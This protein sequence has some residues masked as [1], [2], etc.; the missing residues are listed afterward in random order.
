MRPHIY[1]LNFLLAALL[2]GVASAQRPHNIWDPPF[3]QG[4]AAEVEDTIITFEEIRREMAPL[5]PGIRE[6]S[7]SR[8]E[9]NRQ[10]EELYLE[11]LGSLVDRAI[12]LREF[13]NREFNIPQSFI[14]SR[15][16]Q[17]LAEDFEGD[18]ARFHE[19][20]RNQGKSVREFRRQV[21]EDIIIGAMRS[22]RRRS[23]SQISPER[24]ER[25]YNEN[26]LHF[27][28]E[29]SVRLRVIMLRPLADESPDLMRQQ[30]ERVMDELARGTPFAEVASRFSQDPR[31][32]RGGDW[33]WVLRRNLRDEMAEAAFDLNVGE[34]SDPIT[35]GN[36][37]FIIFVE[38]IREEGIQP[39]N[40]VRER[41]EQILAQ[42][43][44]RQD[45]QQWIE[46]L[47]RNAFIRYY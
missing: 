5:I 25:F 47:R 28:E 17:I 31:R 2:A 19:F 26:K 12:I 10:M 7:R 38:D 13:R 29:E 45:Q 34:Y 37:T 18:R 32:D 4:I 40:E 30:I 41:I 36:Q 3:R 44:A 24:I 15:M 14:E 11:I 35:V 23:Q 1:C 21:H 43:L 16:D 33:G 20:L 6:S 42:Q 27:Y 9:F 46:R 22:E 8:A 39:L